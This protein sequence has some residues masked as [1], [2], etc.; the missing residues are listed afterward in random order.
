MDK[1]LNDLLE[2]L[3]NVYIGEGNELP[4]AYLSLNISNTQFVIPNSILTLDDVQDAAELNEFY[5]FLMSIGFIEDR[6]YS[7]TVDGQ[8]IGIYN[9]SSVMLKKLDTVLQTQMSLYEIV[10]GDP[11]SHVLFNI[12]DLNIGES[13]DELTKFGEVESVESIALTLRDKY[14]NGIVKILENNKNLLVSTVGDKLIITNISKLE[15]VE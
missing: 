5:V 10:T 2:L 9:L 12:V 13:L 4:P 1:L 3:T 15:N 14:K 6:P 8:T 11:L 7:S